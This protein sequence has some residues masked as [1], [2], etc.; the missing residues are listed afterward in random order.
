LSCDKA[1]V[2]EKWKRGQKSIRDKN[3]NWN[4]NDFCPFPPLVA[5][6]SF[7]KT[8]FVYG[9]TTAAG[10][11]L[12]SNDMLAA[13]KYP[14]KSSGGP[15]NSEKETYTVNILGDQKTKTDRNGN[16]HSYSFD[17]LGRQLSDAGKGERAG[18]G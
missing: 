12:N 2:K 10:S 9:V 11:D 15:S 14:D 16:V 5:G 1:F 8:V 17:V 6:G 4:G 7:Q 18:S 3:K 13:T